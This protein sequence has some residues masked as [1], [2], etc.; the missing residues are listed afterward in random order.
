MEDK[1]K[2]EALPEPKDWIE[3]MIRRESKPK[4]TRKDTVSEFCEKWEISD[5]TYFYQKS[6]KENKRRIVQVWLDEA[7]NGG[8]EVLQKLREKALDGDN[9]CM[10]MYLKFVLELA[11]NLDV[12]S[13]GKPIFQ[14]CSEVANKYA[15]D[16]GTN[17]SA[18]V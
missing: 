3:A 10:E 4:P 15:I 7:M 11:E 13:D 16:A 1:V 2:Q 17:S 8:N 18:K 9:K 6:K 5:A 14:I 12:K